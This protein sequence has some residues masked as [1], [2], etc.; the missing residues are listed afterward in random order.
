[1]QRYDVA[2]GG[3]GCKGASGR[4][5]DDV[6]RS[7]DKWTEPIRTEVGDDPQ[8]ATLV[9]EM[10]DVDRERHS[11]TVDG[12]GR[13]DHQPLAGLQGRSAKQSASARPEGIGDVGTLGEH[14]AAG[15]IEYSDL[16]RHPRL[17]PER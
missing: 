4:Q 7:P 2:R 6:V 15:R 5:L 13:H 3:H 12:P 16:A 10:Q 11:D 1:M 8:H 17:V 14:G 9:V